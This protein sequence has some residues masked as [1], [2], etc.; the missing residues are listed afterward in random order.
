[1]AM[2]VTLAV[3]LFLSALDV[4]IRRHDR[5]LS[6]G[7]ASTVLGIIWLGHMLTFPGVIPARPR[8]VAPQASPYL[9][10]LGQ[11]ATPGLLTW[12]LLRRPGPLRDPR[13]SLARTIAIAAGAGG[14]GVT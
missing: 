6:I 12:I 2:V 14:L 8:F 4:I 7:F 1:M 11:I 9:F 3:V 5:L 13:S 10:Q